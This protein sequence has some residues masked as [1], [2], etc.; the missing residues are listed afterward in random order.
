M[1]MHTYL[2]LCIM[3]CYCIMN[4]MHM[5]VGDVDAH[6]SSGKTICVFK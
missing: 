2:R 5:I 6:V 1:P 3:K 4:C